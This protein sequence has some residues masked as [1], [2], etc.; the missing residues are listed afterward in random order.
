MNE[1]YTCKKHTDDYDYCPICR[2]EQ[3]RTDLKKERESCAKTCEDLQGEFQHPF[4]NGAF[5]Q[6]ADAIRKGSK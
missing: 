2:I 6:C 3:L 1:L 4:V 5:K